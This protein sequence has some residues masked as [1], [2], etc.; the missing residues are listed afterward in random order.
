V[1]I[2]GFVL[3]YVLTVEQCVIS[4]LHQPK[5]PLK[6]EGLFVEAVVIGGLAAVAIRQRR[7]RALL[8]REPPRLIGVG[9]QI[10][11]MT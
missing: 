11:F 9:P 6:V 3:L 8:G 2:P 7:V 4:P 10:S 1:V 5:R